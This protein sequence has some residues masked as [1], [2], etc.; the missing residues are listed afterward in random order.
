V[1]VE[2]P[3]HG[4]FEDAEVFVRHEG[5]AFDIKDGHGREISEGV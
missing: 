4:G 3:P 5:G 2:E 1:F